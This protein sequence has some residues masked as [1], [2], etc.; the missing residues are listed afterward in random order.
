MTKRRINIAESKPFKLYNKIVKRKAHRREIEVKPIDKELEDLIKSGKA[1]QLVDKNNL[2]AI[3]FHIDRPDIHIKD[4]WYCTNVMKHTEVNQKDGTPI[5]SY[6]FEITYNP[7]DDEDFYGERHVFAKNE[8]EVK[9]IAKE[10]LEKVN[11]YGLK[12]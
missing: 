5:I 9:K 3:K 8:E 11:Y 10:E 2:S 1:K 7:N 6:S 12:E 4:K